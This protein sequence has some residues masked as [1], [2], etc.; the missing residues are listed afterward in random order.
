MQAAILFYAHNNNLFSCKAKCKSARACPS[1]SQHCRVQTAH[2][3]QYIRVYL[4]IVIVTNLFFEV[5]LFAIA[6]A[7]CLFI[8]REKCERD[9]IDMIE[10]HFNRYYVAIVQQ[11]DP[12]WKSARQRG[13]FKHDQQLLNFSTSRRRRSAISQTT[14]RIFGK[15]ARGNMTYK[16][17]EDKKMLDS[18]NYIRLLIWTILHDSSFIIVFINTMPCY[19]V[20]SSRAQINMIFIDC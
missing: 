16:R 11:R 5:L 18:R 12:A 9:Y 8:S 7:H 4:H 19:V 3:H 2:H 17:W 6:N 13:T 20:V 15:P 10:M 14:S 1:N